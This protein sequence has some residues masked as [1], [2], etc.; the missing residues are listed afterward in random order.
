MGT[1]GELRG[2]SCCLGSGVKRWDRGG[3]FGENRKNGV[4]TGTPKVLESL[5]RKKF[6]K[7]TNRKS[8]ERRNYE[9]IL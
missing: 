6:R 7:S 2:R 9:R 5:T 1:R 4:S 8:F 3:I